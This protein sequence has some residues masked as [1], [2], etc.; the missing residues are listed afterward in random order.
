[1]KTKAYVIFS[2]F[3]FAIV[4]VMHLIRL[5]MDWSVKLGTWNVPLWVSAVVAIAAA[6]LVIWGLFVC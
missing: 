1:M 6:G 4:G 2:T 3:I 5:L